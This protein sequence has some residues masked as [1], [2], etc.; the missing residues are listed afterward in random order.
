MTRE[1][2]L[3]NSSEINIF[4]WRKPSRLV[5]QAYVCQDHWKDIKK[6]LKRADIYTNFVTKPDIEL[7][8]DFQLSMLLQRIP[9]R[10]QNVHDMGLWDRWTKLENVAAGVV[11][12]NDEHVEDATMKGNIVLI[13]VLCGTGL[14]IALVFFSFEL[15]LYRLLLIVAKWLLSAMVKLWTTV[16]KFCPV[17]CPRKIFQI[18]R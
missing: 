11:P 16:L 8:F 12:E 3:M 14:A 1:M 2:S 4:C 10:F 18:L 15:R 13:F 5:A 6:K 7:L 9:R 17:N